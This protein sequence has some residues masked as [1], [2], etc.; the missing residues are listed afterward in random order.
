M[1]EPYPE[2]SEAPW[3][4]FEQGGGVVVPAMGRAR[5]LEKT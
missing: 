2:V 4:T 1:F 3:R 5:L